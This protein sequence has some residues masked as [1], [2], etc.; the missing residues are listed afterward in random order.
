MNTT[1]RS[2][3]DDAF[4]YAYKKCKSME[5]DKLTEIEIK[6]TKVKRASCS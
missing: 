6:I 3:F 5:I 4:N 1:Q 2:F